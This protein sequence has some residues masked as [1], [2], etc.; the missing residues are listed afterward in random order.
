MQNSRQQILKYLRD[1]NMAS[2]VEISRALHMTAA[3]ARHH[4]SVLENQGLIEEIGSRPSKSRGRPSKLFG[5]SA[6]VLDNNI[7]ALATALLKS[8]LPAGNLDTQLTTLTNHLFANLSVDVVKT[9][10]L[11]RLN[12]TVQRLN[13]A[14]YQARWEATP[15]GPRILLGH[16][17]YAAILPEHPE[18]CQ[19][20]RIFLS[21]QLRQSVKQIAKLERNPQGS[22]YCIFSIHELPGD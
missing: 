15:I 9:S 1:H 16:C 11:Q 19:M 14:G 7:H 5:L 4:F 21:Q 22:P 2:A 20:D 3:N 13:H 18:L 17:P 8:F 6:D 10:S 12:Q